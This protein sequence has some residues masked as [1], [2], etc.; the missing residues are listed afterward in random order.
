MS[1]IGRLSLDLDLDPAASRSAS[2]SV[3]GT[4]MPICSAE[5]KQRAI[6]PQHAGIVS[7]R[8]GLLEVNR[9]FMNFESKPCHAL[10]TTDLGPLLVVEVVDAMEDMSAD[11]SNSSLSSSD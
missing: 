6:G 11:L 5:V 8:L 1:S 7:I 4:D 9:G 2:A 3:I 10:A